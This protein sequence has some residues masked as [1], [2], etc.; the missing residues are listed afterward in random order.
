[1]LKIS[2][3]KRAT[4]SLVLALPY[5]TERTAE[6]MDEE[7]EFAYAVTPKMIPQAVTMTQ[8]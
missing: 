4:A 7:A 5:F 1:M 2:A 3:Q 8:K 6:E